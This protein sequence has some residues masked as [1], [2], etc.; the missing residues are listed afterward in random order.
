MSRIKG[1]FVQDK[2]ITDLQILLRNNM[3]LEARNAG[4]SANI[5]ILKLSA[6]D[7]LTLLREVSMDGNKVTNMADP[8]DP[9]DAVT[10]AFLE[11]F[12]AGLRDPKES[13]R[14]ATTGELP[15]STY[16][17]GAAGVGATLTADANGAL[18]SQDGVALSPE[19][20]ILVKNQS[21][22]LENGIYK[23]TQLGDAG[24]P[25]ILTRT[26]DADNSAGDP[27][28]VTQGMFCKVAEGADNAS[29]GYILTTK[30]SGVD[31]QGALVLGTDALLFAQLG[32]VIIA[33]NGLVKSGQTV[34][35][36]NGDGLG[37]SG[38]EL[39]VLVDDDLVN[40]TTDIKGGNVVG[41]KTFE[42]AFTLNATDI[43]NGYIDL[44][45]VASSESEVIYPRF[46]IKQS[47]VVDWT[48]SYQ[49]GASSKT[50]L[51]FTGDLASILEDGD[52][53]DIRFESLDY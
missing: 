46:G 32:E 27:T 12:L 53:L 25:W 15:A 20:R 52:V 44:S 42:E 13:V 35:V 14:V 33:G 19:E 29:L 43:S 28:L 6:T 5:G 17:N 26:G 21:T 37:F 16:A 9:Q 41:R 39:V 51:T 3:P 10:K 8:V 23:V 11:N 2:T 36:D 4:D 48:A 30:S 40:G 22:A 49:G 7:I 38:N 47:K 24:N 45:K 34:S 18:A 1:K 50:R 31:P